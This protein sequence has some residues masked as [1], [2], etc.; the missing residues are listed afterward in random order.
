MYTPSPSRGHLKS[1]IGFRFQSALRRSVCLLGA[2]LANRN[3]RA[4]RSPR[5]WAGL[6][7]RAWLRVTISVSCDLQQ[8]FQLEHTD[9]LPL[10]KGGE[11]Q[12]FWAEVPLRVRWEGDGREVKAYDAL[13]GQWSRVIQSTNLY[14]IPGATYSGA[15]GKFPE[16]KSPAT[17]KHI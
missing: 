8:S 11:Y 14:G 5:Q 10:T 9:W 16:S 3:G 2:D 7:G 12:P 13:H 1:A 17:R 6:R 15:H 4:T